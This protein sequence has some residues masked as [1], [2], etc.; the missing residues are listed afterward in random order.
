MT[1][2]RVIEYDGRPLSRRGAAMATA[3]AAGERLREIAAK[4]QARIDGKQDAAPGDTEA[5]A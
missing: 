1:V 5:S 3:R 2:K 4:R